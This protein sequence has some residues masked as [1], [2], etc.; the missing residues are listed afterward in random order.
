M[1]LKQSCINLMDTSRGH[2][3][4]LNL[5][6]VFPVRPVLKIHELEMFSTGHTVHQAVKN[7]QQRNITTHMA[8]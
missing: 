1:D 4:L 3:D 6:T 5:D 2:I 7:S 8:F